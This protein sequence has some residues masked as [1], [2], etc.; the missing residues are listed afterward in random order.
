MDVS[1]NHLLN[2]YDWNSG[3]DYT[4]PGWYQVTVKGAGT[5]TN[6][7][8]ECVEWLYKNIDNP[9]RHARWVSLFGES[10]FRF[11]Y[12]RD[13]VWFRLTWE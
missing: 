13:Y 4:N 6:K 1:N 12:E 9:E 11:R 2:L 10:H 8:Y 3:W 5:Q 7:H